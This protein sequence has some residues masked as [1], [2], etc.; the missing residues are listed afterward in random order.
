MVL[1]CR[2]SGPRCN[3]ITPSKEG[4]AGAAG[5][6]TKGEGS[7]GLALA[8]KSE[9]PPRGAGAVDEGLRADPVVVFGDGEP[10]AAAPLL[11]RD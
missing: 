8:R 2:V 1:F 6:L 9:L 3:R 4:F 11:L 5:H 7:E 10:V